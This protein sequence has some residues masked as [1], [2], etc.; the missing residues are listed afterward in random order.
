MKTE[1][2]KFPRN[3][4]PNRMPPKPP[5][6]PPPSPPR[7]AADDSPLKLVRLSRR[8]DSLLT[9]PFHKVNDWASVRNFQGAELG[10][11]LNIR[12]LWPPGRSPKCPWGKHTAISAWPTPQERCVPL[13]VCCPRPT[14]GLG[15]HGFCYNNIFSFQLQLIGPFSWDRF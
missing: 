14:R 9:W 15:S 1:Q 5:G 3:E 4:L 11:P 12:H 8:L 7:T 2:P 6:L 10:S 13:P